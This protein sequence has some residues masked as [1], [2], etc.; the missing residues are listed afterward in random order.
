MT[1]HTC[2]MT[3][4]DLND[5]EHDFR[6]FLRKVREGETFVV[7]DAGRAVAEIKPIDLKPPLDRERPIG[8]ADGEFEVPDD[9]DDPLPDDVLRLFEPE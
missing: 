9:F 6:S 3:T 8:L 2:A 7:T 4:A 1:Y 5:V